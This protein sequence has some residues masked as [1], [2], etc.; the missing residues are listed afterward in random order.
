MRLV[1]LPLAFALLAAFGASLGSAQTP[2]AGLYGRF[3]HVVRN[4]RTYADPYRDVTLEGSFSGPNGTTV[5][6]WGFYDGGDQWRIRFMPNHSGTW[7]WS[8]AFSDGSGSASGSFECVAADIPGMLTRYPFNPMWFGYSSGANELIRGLHV[9]DRFFA[10]NW[11][12][13]KRQA[14]LDWVSANHYNLLSIASHYLNRAEPGRGE[15]WDTP[16]L[17]PLDA[18]EYRKMEAILDELARRGILVFPFAGFFGQDSDY[19]RDPADQ[20][21]YVRYTLARL[22]SYWNVLFNVAGPEPNLRGKGRWMSD[23][24]VERLG[25]MIRDLDVFHHALAVHNRTGDDPFRD[26]DWSTYGVVQGPKTVDLDELSAGLLESHNGAKP[27][28]AQE[29]L[30]SGNVNHIRRIGRDYSDADLRRNAIVMIMSAAAIVFA[31]NDG[32]SSTG[33]SG[34]LEVAAAKQRRHDILEGVWDIF[35]QLPFYRMKPAQDLVDSGYALADPG[36]TYL[37]YLPHG[38]AVNVAVKRGPF[39]V[40]WINPREPNNRR[41][42]GETPDGQGLAAPDD[43]DWLLY[44]QP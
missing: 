8:A 41:E 19:P 6:L 9:G 31:D 32:N 18:A 37:V 38:G 30:W 1:V 43:S 34:T 28:L 10:E 14:F 29:T 27:L 2:E 3:E 24:D 16:D 13:A 39:R 7:E 23:D 12:D 15:G 44:L 33:F 36:R 26:S 42:A 35:E 22:G 11:P 5:K 25:R 40:E 17:W 20:E 21:T 4:A